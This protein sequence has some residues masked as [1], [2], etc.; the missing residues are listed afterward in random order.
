M[1]E[2]DRDDHDDGATDGP[3]ATSHTGERLQKVLARTGVGSRRVCEELIVDGRV[4]VNGE[5]PVLGR[6]VD[7]TV[8]VIELDGV[9]LPVR[10]G[11]RPLPGQQ[12]GRRGLARPRTPTAGPR[13]W[14]WC[15]PSPGCSRSAGSTWTPRA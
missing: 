15:P 2:G 8:D 3:T 13:W 14:R 11:P 6:R 10:P 4:T 5:V 7:P 12:A 9:P 1:P